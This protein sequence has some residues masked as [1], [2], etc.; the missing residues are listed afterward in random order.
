[1][2]SAKQTA[3]K[4]LKSSTARKRRQNQNVE[5]DELASLVPL[6]QTSPVLSDKLSVLRLVTTFLKLQNFMKDSESTDYCIAENFCGRKCSP[7]PAAFVL[8]RGI[9]F[10]Q[11]SKGRHILGRKNSWIK[12]SR[13]WRNRRKFSPGENLKISGYM[14]CHTTVPF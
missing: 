9:Y 3:S 8:L 12:L 10:C 2:Y 5:I 1:M 13:R 6:S 7:S 4:R 11:Y 14:V